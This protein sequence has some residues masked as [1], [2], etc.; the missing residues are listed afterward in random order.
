LSRRCER[1]R[2]RSKRRAIYCPIHSCHMDSVSQKHTIF[3]DDIGQL[4][5][6]GIGKR[7]AQFLLASQNTVLLNGEWLE[8]FWCEQCQQTKW[9]H[10]QKEERTYHVSVAPEHLWRQAIGVLPIHG[11]PSVS[12]FTKA[13]ARFSGYQM[14]PTYQYFA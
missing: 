9:Y 12:E 1:N 3:T 7:N 11:N 10:I 2:K 14:M 13:Q 8:A 5:Q 6:K 4:R